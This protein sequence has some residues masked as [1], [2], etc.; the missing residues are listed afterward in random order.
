MSVLLHLKP[1]L[2]TREVFK[3]VIRVSVPFQ[4]CIYLYFI[5]TVVINPTHDGANE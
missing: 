5:R 2:T 4:N 1:W 3:S